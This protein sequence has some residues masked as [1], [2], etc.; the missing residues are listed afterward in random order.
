MKLDVTETRVLRVNI[1][2]SSEIHFRSFFSDCMLV[3]SFSS[4]WALKYQMLSHN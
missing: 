2:Q 1:L 4:M 3:I